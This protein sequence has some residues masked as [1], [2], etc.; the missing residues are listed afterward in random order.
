MVD[1]W[2]VK[3]LAQLLCQRTVCH[4]A[5][6]LQVAVVIVTDQ[7]HW[8]H[9]LIAFLEFFHF[10]PRGCPDSCGFNSLNNQSPKNIRNLG[11]RFL[12]VRRV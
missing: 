12:K 2:A 9:H 8:R 5:L 10:H 7:K 3:F 6:H 4:L 11:I 1:A